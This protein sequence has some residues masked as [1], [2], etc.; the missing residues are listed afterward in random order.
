MY[1]YVFLIV[2]LKGK[3][4]QKIYVFRLKGLACIVMTEQAAWPE[5]L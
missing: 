2:N 4:V 5:N 1:D 3:G